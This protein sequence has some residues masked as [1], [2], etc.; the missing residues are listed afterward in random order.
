M[1][2]AADDVAGRVRG[3]LAPPAG[4]VCPA[5][6]LALALCALLLPLIAVPRYALLHELIERLVA[7]GR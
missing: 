2:V 5:I 1:P 7:L 3:L 6:A 4:A